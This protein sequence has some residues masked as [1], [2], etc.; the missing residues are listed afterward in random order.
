[1]S[2]KN[3]RKSRVYLAGKES[4]VKAVEL[5]KTRLNNKKRSW[6][7]KNNDKCQK[8]TNRCTSMPLQK[9][10]DYVSLTGFSKSLFMLEIRSHLGKQN[11]KHIQHLFPFLLDYSNEVEYLI[12]RYALTILLYSD[13]SDLSNLQEFLEICVGNHR[14]NDRK[15]LERLLLLRTRK[16]S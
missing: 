11:W 8:M 13:N 1:M 12:W 3:K 10:S 5:L 7:N 9:K 2:D 15:E 4:T 6:N 16:N 14:L